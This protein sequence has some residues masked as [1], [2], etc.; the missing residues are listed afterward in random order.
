MRSQ[1]LGLS[2]NPLVFQYRYPE[3]GT[4]SVSLP[5]SG[6]FYVSRVNI[7][8][9]GK[10]KNAVQVKAE[11]SYLVAADDIEIGFGTKIPL[12]LFGFLYCNITA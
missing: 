7:E 10:S 2:E 5:G 11:P 9:G 12:W 3:P 8:V 6:D 1:L 4:L